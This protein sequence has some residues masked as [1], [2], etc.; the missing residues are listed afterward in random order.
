MTNIL[1]DSEKIAIFNKATKNL[2]DAH[3]GYNN[4]FTEI[5]FAEYLE[6]VS[7]R[8]TPIPEVVISS[9]VNTVWQ[10]YLGNPW[11]VSTGAYPNYKFMLENLTP[12]GIEV[13]LDLL[14]LGS[15][16]SENTVD[17]KHHSIQDI[18]TYYDDSTMLNTNQISKL[19]Q[20]KSALNL[21]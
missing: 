14:G 21:K 8:I 1:N 17:W 2:E 10:C 19:S 13:L 18:V 4:F 9:Y 15:T 3:N 6:D 12:K 7:K 16:K 20:I 5:P 11:G